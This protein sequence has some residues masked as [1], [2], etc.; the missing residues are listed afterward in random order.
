[1]RLSE[2]TLR[3]VK[4]IKTTLPCEEESRLKAVGAT[5]SGGF[6]VLYSSKIGCVINTDMCLTGISADIAAKITVEYV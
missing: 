4:I 6:L 2:A 3:R 5:S 1:M